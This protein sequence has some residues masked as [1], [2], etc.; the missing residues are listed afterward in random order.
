MEEKKSF[1]SLLAEIDSVL[2]KLEHQDLELEQS[3]QLYEDG[4][5]AY[6]LAVDRLTEAKARLEQVVSVSGTG[7][8]AVVEKRPVDIEDAPF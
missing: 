6:Q 5:K 8:T 3:L 4:M 2:Q 1:E 7:D